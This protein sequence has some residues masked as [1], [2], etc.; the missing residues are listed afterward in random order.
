MKYIAPFEKKINSKN[1][2]EVFEYFLKTLKNTITSWD[3]FVNW[4]KVF[5]NIKNIEIELNILNYLIGKDDIESEL[6]YLLKNHPSIA[7]VIPGLVACR[8]KNFYLLLNFEYKEFNYKNYSFKKSK[9]LSDE[10]IKNI[11]EFSKESG[12][13]NLIQKEKV[14]SLVDYLIGV[15]VGLD[16]NGRK[17]RTGTKMEEI[18]EFYV[19]E[20][21][22]RCNYEYL[23]Q[24]TS[25]K[26]KEKWGINLTVD[27]S[28]R[29]IDFSIYNGEYLYLIETNFYGGSGS[30]LKSTA[31]EYKTMF[32]YWIND[33]HK[34]IWITDGI[35]WNSTKLPLLE[36]FNHI[37]YILNLDMVLKGILEEII[38][39]N[40]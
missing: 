2:E 10:E 8:E 39:N 28:S 30:K 37:D 25:L 3:Y 19:Q 40:E 6:E 34:F 27:K 29:R 11:I 12:F 9:E 22:K 21:C 13:L 17:N 1:Q 16:S 26:I 14:K 32:D 24:A 38:V 36:T 31:G 18:I 35:G 15:E 4:S 23:V 7:N 20:I 33:G 5:G